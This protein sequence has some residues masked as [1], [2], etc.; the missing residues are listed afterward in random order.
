VEV[1]FLN[2]SLTNCV[3]NTVHY[4]SKTDSWIPNSP[5][6]VARTE[7][8]SRAVVFVLKTTFGRSKCGCFRMMNERAALAANIWAIPFGTNA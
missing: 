2:F 4:N 1:H 5:L 8:H 6:G 3:G 7:I